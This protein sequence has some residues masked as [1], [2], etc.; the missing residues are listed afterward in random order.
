MEAISDTLA[1]VVQYNNDASSG[2]TIP[3][4]CAALNGTSAD[5]TG[6]TAA[7]AL[8]ALIIELNGEDTCL[9]VSYDQYIQDLQ[10]DGAMR[11]W[12]YQTCTEF[13]YFQTGDSAAQPFSKAIDIDYFYQ[14]CVDAFPQT[15][16]PDNC[17]VDITND[18]FGA[19]NILQTAQN[20]YFGDGTVDPW[21]AL[22]AVPNTSDIYAVGYKEV[23]TDS[24]TVLIEGTSHCADMYSALSTDPEGLTEA[25]N[26]AFDYISQ[27]V[28]AS[29]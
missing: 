17:G 13:A 21:H 12:T 16:L 22:A 29:N 28:G 8:G 1:G 14:I 27:W 20:T 7:K 5:S 24:V 23:G 2:M 25:R 3:K 10:E 15:T 9:E 4:M 18:H 6:K 11:S 26:I 19:L